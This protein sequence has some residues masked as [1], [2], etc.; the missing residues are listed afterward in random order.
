MWHR[1]GRTEIAKV[2][3]SAN[4]ARSWFTRVGRAALLRQGRLVEP[5]LLHRASVNCGIFGNQVA[6]MGGM[7]VGNRLTRWGSAR[8]S[9]RIS[10]SIPIL[11]AGIAAATII[12]TM[13]RKGVVSGAL[14]TGLN[15]MPGIGAAKN[16]IEVMRGR[17]FFPDRPR[18]VRK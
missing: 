1:L 5:D 9:R 3:K 18:A 8:L 12:A 4:I 6:E 13:R 16:V 17:D 7:S 14:D 10:R 15:A 11:G 2:A